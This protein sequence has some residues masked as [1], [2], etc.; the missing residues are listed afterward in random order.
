MRV[1]NPF[2]ERP[3]I[4]QAKSNGYL[5]TQFQLILNVFEQKLPEPIP[6]RNLRF[7]S[8]LS[9]ISTYCCSSSIYEI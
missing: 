7:D 8:L 4:I 2:Y 6:W 9:S 3:I 5:A 1:L